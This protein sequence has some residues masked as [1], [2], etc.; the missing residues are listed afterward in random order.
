[1]F[2]DIFQYPTRLELIASSSQLNSQ[3][4][5]AILLWNSIKMK[6]TYDQGWWEPQNGRQSIFHI[7]EGWIA[8]IYICLHTKCSPILPPASCQAIYSLLTTCLLHQL[9]T[10]K[11]ISIIATN[12]YQYLSTISIIAI[13]YLDNHD[14]DDRSQKQSLVKASNKFLRAILTFNVSFLV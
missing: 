6:C 7:S 13:I 9:H 10:I 3:W 5:F 4:F 2:Q 12:I 1:M 14:Q 8:K 11:A